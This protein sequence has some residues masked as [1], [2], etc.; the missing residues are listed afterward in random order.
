MF[1]KNV[2]QDFT[3]AALPKR[4]TVQQVRLLLVQ[5]IGHER[6]VDAFGPSEVQPVGDVAGDEGE[7]AAHVFG[8]LQ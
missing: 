3:R 4:D 1:E 6:A 2:N 8:Q 5:V 7:Q